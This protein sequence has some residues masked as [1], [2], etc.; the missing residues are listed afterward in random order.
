MGWRILHNDQILKAYDLPIKS[1][2][3]I[4]TD[5]GS[6]M[7]KALKVLNQIEYQN[8]INSM[9]KVIEEVASGKLFT[10]DNFNLLD[11]ND[12]DIHW[13]SEI[14]EIESEIILKLKI[15][16]LMY[17]FVISRDVSHVMLILCS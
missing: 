5:N 16:K 15:K 17:N 7:I 8:S 1:I 3:R 12:K 10:I 14:K 9:E 2:S 11:N 4:V 13:E 6:N